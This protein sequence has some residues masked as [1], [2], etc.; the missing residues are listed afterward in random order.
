LGTHAIPENSAGLGDLVTAALGLQIAD[1]KMRDTLRGWA[2]G[3]GGGGEERE[4]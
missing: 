1:A 3:G 4:I 2:G